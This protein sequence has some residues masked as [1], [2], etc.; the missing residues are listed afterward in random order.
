MECVRAFS[1][2]P[3]HSEPPRL[4]LTELLLSLAPFTAWLSDARRSTCVWSLQQAGISMEDA[5][6]IKAM[7]QIMRY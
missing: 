2:S 7:L 6:L 5:M 3:C 1:P 4:L